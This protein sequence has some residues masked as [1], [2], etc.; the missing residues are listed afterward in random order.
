MPTHDLAS[1]SGPILAPATVFGAA[2]TIAMLG[3]LALVV[4]PRRVRARRAIAAG[5][6]PLLL[7]VAYSALIAAGWSR[8]DGGFDSIAG[9]RSL[10]ASDMALVAGWL[11]Y[12]AFDLLV[13]T[14]IDERAE[15]AS[16]GR[17][18]LL[19]ALSLTFLF[20][21]LGWLLYRTQEWV[22]LR[23]RGDGMP[24][25]EVTVASG[26]IATLAGAM[27][28]ADRRLLAIAGGLLMIVPP[29]AMAALLDDRMLDG[30]NPW[31]K[32]LKFELSL[33]V[34]MATLSVL[35]PL[36]GTH[37]A[38][39]R[40]ARWMAW[41]GA[42]T[43]LL[44]MLW[45]IFQA[46]RGA[47]SHFNLSTPFEGTMYGVMGVGAVLLVLMPLPLALV[48]WRARSG[49]LRAGI[50]A[51]LLLNVLLGGA[52]GAILSARESHFIGGDGTDATGLPFVGWSTTG[53][54][55]RIAHFLGLHGLQ[56]ML[57]IGVVASAW[58]PRT[59]TIAVW[60]VATAWAA[61]TVTAGT[62][63]L[64]GVPLP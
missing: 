17:L 16:I 36:A 60:T 63:A 57:A 25:T 55:L 12:L 32:P 28:G 51:G 18:A 6:I 44:E 13:G 14:V 45:I 61:A 11:H 46:G 58:R 48:A 56:A 29:T 5:A 4:L 53:G 39:S 21:P 3:W 35:V 42:T 64:R 43:I 30:A 38:T 52:F 34:Y 49:G 33:A 15:R 50:V 37:A 19:P 10:F 22:T 24:V 9:V 40:T 23:M 59:G 8:A 41:I 20:G 62:L 2:N 27:R 26:W 7:A 1:A 47:R 54:D 31:I